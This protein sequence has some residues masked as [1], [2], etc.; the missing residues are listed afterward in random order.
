MD[1]SSF[2]QA[3]EKERDTLAEQLSAIAV[4]NPLNPADWEAKDPSLDIMEAD[5]NEVGD[6]VEERFS[7]LAEQNLLESRYRDVLRA[8][9]KIAAGTFGVCEISA[10]PIEQDRLSANP[11]ART[12][13]AHMEREHEL[14]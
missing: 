9:E 12:C 6:R 3:L 13:K 8:L 14:L 7:N 11:A 4:V 1:V 10:E 2:A 5:L